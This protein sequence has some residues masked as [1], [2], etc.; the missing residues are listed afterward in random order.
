M[1]QM[2][3]EKAA[4]PRNKAQEDQ[5][6]EPRFETSQPMVLTV[7]GINPRPV[8]EACTLNI[9]NRGLRL[10]VPQPVPPGTLI[11]ADARET[12]MLGE[13]LRCVQIDGAYHLGIRL[14]Q[15]LT[16]ASDLSRLNRHLLQEDLWADAGEP[17]RIARA[18]E[19]MHP[20][21]PT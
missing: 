14:F 19:Q 13:V 5:R 16:G 6:K 2:G 7:L 18:I 17:G 15:P 1:N 4:Q 8:M 11:K 3:A 9:S 21:K 12:R 10:R 20:R